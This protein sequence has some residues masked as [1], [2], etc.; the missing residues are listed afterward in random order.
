LDKQIKK[1]PFSLS[2]NNELNIYKNN[3]RDFSNQK[4]KQLNDFTKNKFN[5]NIEN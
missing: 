4:Q 5:E 2:N 1:L 3:I